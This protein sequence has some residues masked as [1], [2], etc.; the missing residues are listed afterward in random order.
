MPNN[1]RTQLFL[2]FFGITVLFA[3]PGDERWENPFGGEWVGGD[4]RSIALFSNEVYAAGQFTTANGA[5]AGH[6]AKWN[7]TNWL[8]LMTNAYAFP[9]SPVVAV[10]A[11]N[12]FLFMADSEGA[13]YKWT[14]TNWS[15]LNGYTGFWTDALCGSGSNLYAAGYMIIGQ[16]SY[17][18]AKW[19][20]TAWSGIAVTN[21]LFTSLAAAGTNLYA[22]GRF[23]YIS[24]FS[25]GGGAFATNIAR[26][27]GTF[28][29]PLGNGVNGTVR[30]LASAGA[31]VYVGGDFTVAGTVS[32]SHVAKWDGTSW[33]ALGSG[34][35]GRVNA[36]TTIGTN[37][38]AAGTFS[39]AGG[40]AC[41]NLALWNGTSWTAVNAQIQGRLQVLA[42]NGNTL[43]VG[44]A[45]D[46][47][48]DQRVGNI[49]S[50]STN[51]WQKLGSGVN[52]ALIN[53]LVTNKIDVYCGGSWRC[54]G[55]TNVSGIAKFDGQN[56]NALGTG[57]TNS[58]GDTLVND[59]LVRSNE[60]FVVGG[61][62]KAG[63]IAATN[64]AKWNGTN[65]QAVG[66]GLTNLPTESG[67]PMVLASYGNDIYAGSSM[68]P[69]YLAKWD[70]SN[71][72]SVGASG[73]NST[74]RALAAFQNQLYVGGYFS[75]APVSSSPYL[76]RWNGTSWSG[77]GT[78]ALN[79]AVTTMAVVGSNLFVAGWF[80]SVGN[81][82]ARWNGT[83]W[84]TL[85]TGL[86]NFR[87]SRL[88]AVG[89][90]LYAGGDF[91]TAGG[92]SA[93]GIAKWNGT[94]WTNLGS[95]VS[96]LDVSVVSAMAANFNELIVG[97][98]FFNAGTNTANC[99]GVWRLQNP[100]MMARKSGNL[101]IVS[102]P[103]GV[104]PFT[105][106]RATDLSSGD[107]ATVDD[108]RVVSNGT[109]NV[110]TELLFPNQFF[111][112]KKQ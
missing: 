45:L 35:N 46:Y 83:S 12:Q 38:Y 49:F 47:V 84:A 87:V 29:Y 55:G 14:G 98:S 62:D 41:T 18:L 102:W 70:G 101:G 67:V 90:D 16:Q 76:V 77:V 106:Q 107:W 65:W 110:F 103:A 58:V 33:S 89:S 108:P 5:A 7:G 61:F 8:S 92:V 82:I 11:N 81:H 53:V 73:P 78:T 100:Q 37:V 4:V 104:T 80:T 10:A 24:Q 71:W 21:D 72:S 20:G 97:G 79:G 96:G 44:G 39:V 31:D 75:S 1:I 94:T 56:W 34:V 99:L 13:I 32:A 60:V 57:L 111:R 40:V 9:D 59:I 93:R 42:T 43:F 25:G 6:I 17:Y 69:R 26:F 23:T 63:G 2:L 3:A 19:N 15:F 105:L 95:G 51:T 30:C 48:D 28:W 64:V 74:V 66:G 52:F 27:N 109:N 54:I 85:G 91:T 86:N 68:Y 36:I 88:T 112:L 22:G 50:Y